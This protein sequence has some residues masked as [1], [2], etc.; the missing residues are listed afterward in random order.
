MDTA[1]KSPCRAALTGC[2]HPADQLT[3]L[4]SARDFVTQHS[5]QI[6]SCKACGFAVTIP[7]PSLS[8]IGTYYPAGYYGNPG[9]RRF[10]WIIET[11][12]RSLYIRRVRMVEGVSGDQRGRVL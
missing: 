5:F 10:P 4:F 9:D 7:Q 6:A 12:Q 2:R 3:I 8:E 11:M 1:K